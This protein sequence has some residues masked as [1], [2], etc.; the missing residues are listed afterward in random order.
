[1]EVRM[2]I[3]V[4]PIISSDPT[5]LR[6]FVEAG[7]AG[8][9]SDELL[10]REV[11]AVQSAVASFATSGEVQLFTA[12]DGVT[13]VGRISAQK[14]RAR[15]IDGAFGYFEC[16]DDLAVAGQLWAACKAWHEHRSTSTIRGPLNLDMNGA[17]G[18]LTSGFETPPYV[19]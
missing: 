5:R 1:R 2:A 9:L 18:L 17:V 16:V 12:Y 4:L 13:P 19:G 8:G 11:S 3:T 6:H 14:E 15:S 10:A 7:I